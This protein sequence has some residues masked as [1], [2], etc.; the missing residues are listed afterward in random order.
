[1]TSSQ[2]DSTPPASEDAADTAKAKRKGSVAPRTFRGRIGAGII[3]IIPL[4]VTAVLVRWVYEAALNVGAIAVNWVWK[5]SLWATGT[6]PHEGAHELV[7]GM[8]SVHHE[9]P[10]SI[11]GLGQAIRELHV[12]IAHLKDGPDASQS[13][14]T[15]I[16]PANPDWIDVT[17]AIGLTLLMFYLLG[18]LGTNVVGRRIIGFVESLVERIPLVATVYSAIKRMVQSLSG[19]G[20]P[21][22]EKQQVVLIDFPNE[23][24]KAVAFMTNLITDRVSEQTYATVY[25]PTTPNPTSGYM[26]MVPV[27]QI[28]STD[29]SMENALSMILSGGA[30][31]KPEVHLSRRPNR[32]PMEKKRKKGPGSTGGKEK[33]RSD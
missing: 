2:P 23:N 29:W 24:M 27:E 28:T 8:G 16:D 3:I 7:D 10:G 6:R 30:T 9:A 26:L 18:W 14:K 21:G 1:M 15:L 22:E 19:V 25:L 33:K 31:A 11:Q 4:T 20:K 32:H 17:M 5:V 13:M 12:A